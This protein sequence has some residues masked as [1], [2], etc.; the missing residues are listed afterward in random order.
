MA[1]AS[2]L[3]A[4]DRDLLAAL[5]LRDTIRPIHKPNEVWTRCPI[6]EPTGPCRTR[7]PIT[8]HATR[9]TISCREE[10]P[11]ARVEDLLLSRASRQASRETA[12]PLPTSIDSAGTAREN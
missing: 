11:P 10:C 1:N 5:E 9:L 2:T 7:L 8:P 12:P 6:C 3:N 4:A